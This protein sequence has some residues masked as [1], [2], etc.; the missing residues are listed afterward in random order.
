MVGNML[1]SFYRY[2][3]QGKQE[4]WVVFRKSQGKPGKIRGMLYEIFFLSGKS[5]GNF[6]NRLPNRLMNSCV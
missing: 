1:H 4:K 5:Q 2:G 6:C 3:K